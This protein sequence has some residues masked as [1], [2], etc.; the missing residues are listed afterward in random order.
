MSVWEGGEGDGRQSVYAYVRE[1][2][3]K[4]NWQGGVNV[5]GVA[6]IVGVVLYTHK[7]F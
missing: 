2:G 5:V 4:E 1:Q 7:V 3:K 6:C